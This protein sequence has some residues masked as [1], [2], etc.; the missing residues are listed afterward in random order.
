MGLKGFERRLERMVEGVFARAF[1]SGLRPVELGRRLVREI[2]DNRS[3]DVRGRMVAPN[4]FSIRLS[5]QDLTQFEDIRDTLVR[6]LADAARE[7]ARDEGY[8]FLGPVEVELD[9]DPNM[10]TGA[11]VIEPRMKEG[12]GGAGP[13]ALV[14]PTEERVTLGEQVLSIGRMPE[15][16]IVLA[17]PNV[18]RHH[19]EIRPRGHGFVVIDLSSTN[20]TRVNNLR[21][22]EKDL[23]DGDVLQFGNT[24]IRFEAS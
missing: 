17:D 1:R 13:G 19:A 9:E 11:F 3:L 18:S 5:N 16:N 23:E 20:G 12:V 7:H 21:V 14:L 2:D 8:T 24:H 15:C 22:T 10:H 4:H 6:E